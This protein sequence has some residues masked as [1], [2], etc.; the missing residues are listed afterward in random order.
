M[1]CEPVEHEVAVGV[2]VD[3]DAGG[4]LTSRNQFSQPAGAWLGSVTDDDARVD[5]RVVGEPAG[6]QLVELGP[7]ARR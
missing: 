5:R 6:V 2:G 7:V 4:V 1:G 3:G